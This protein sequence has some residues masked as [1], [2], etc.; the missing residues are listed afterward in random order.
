MREIEIKAHVEHPEELKPIIDSLL[1]SEGTFQRKTDVYYGRKSEN[2]SPLSR[3]AQFRLRYLEDSIIITRKS[4]QLQ[5]GGVENN[6][7]IEF[8][9]SIAEQQHIKNFFVSLDFVIVAEKEKTGWYWV[10]DNLTIE[11]IEI[12]HL[13][14]FIEVEY[15]LE[16]VAGDDEINAVKM[17]LFDFLAAC[18]ISKQAVESRYYLDLIEE[19]SLDS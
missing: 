8:S 7:E 17:K 1:D 16:D 19:I 15:L 2:N 18:H 9:V 14:W 11:L 6:S 10:K 5:T 4:K 13:G 12:T 3:A